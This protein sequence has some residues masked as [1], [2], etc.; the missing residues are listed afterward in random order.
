MTMAD[1]YQSDDRSRRYGS[2][3]GRQAEQFQSDSDDERGSRQMG[4][5]WRDDDYRSQQAGWQTDE[6]HDRERHPTD[7]YGAPLTDRYGNERFGTSGYGPARFSPGG[8]RNFAS[9]TGNDFGGAD[10]SSGIGA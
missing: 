8:G 1:R 6:R 3:R 5:S 9:F 4:E 2:Q 7:D 10:F